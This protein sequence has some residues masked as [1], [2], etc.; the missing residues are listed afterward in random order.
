[1]PNAYVTLSA[2]KGTAALNFT[3]T[4][5]DARLL[6][7]VEAVSR[8]VDAYC[9]RHF[10]PLTETRNFDGP[11][12]SGTRLPLPD[13]VALTAVT[14]DTNSDG[15]FETTWTTSDYVAWPYNAAPTSEWGRGHMALLVNAKSNGS[16]DAWL[17]GQQMYQVAGTWGW[18]AFVVD[19]GERGSGTLSATGTALTLTAS[20]TLSVGETVRVENEYLYVIGTG[21]AGTATGTGIVTVQRAVNGST[22]TAH[23]TGTVQS[24]VFPLEVREACLIQVARLLKRRESGFATQIVFLETG[25]VATFSSELDPDVKAMLA[26]Y[27]RVAV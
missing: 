17:T 5:Y 15:T 25:A 12:P 19:T 3:G 23:S 21:T 4:A 24:L 27:R 8:Q 2:L 22:G 18:R 26:R 16:Q 14:E 7:L 10:Y 9:G 1:M 6:T 11:S 13:F 20:S